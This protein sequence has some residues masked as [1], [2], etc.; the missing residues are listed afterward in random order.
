MVTVIRSIFLEFYRLKNTTVLGLELGLG[1][2]ATI[3][4]ESFSSLKY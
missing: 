4:R 3:R 1:L 2:T